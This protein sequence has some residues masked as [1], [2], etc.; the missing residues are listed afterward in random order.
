VQ[1]LKVPQVVPLQQ[2]VGRLV[3]LRQW[4]VGLCGWVGEFVW[5]RLSKARRTKGAS[6]NQT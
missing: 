5:G 2:M 4:E 6:G 1:L 3:F